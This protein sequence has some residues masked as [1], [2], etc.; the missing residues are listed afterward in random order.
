MNADM[1]E[2]DNHRV[3]HSVVR[4][5]SIQKAL[6]EANG[7]VSVDTI[8]AILEQKMPYGVFCPYYD[9]Y[10]GTLHSMVFDVSNTKVE[11]CLGM[12]Q[13]HKWQ[14]ISFDAPIKISSTSEK[15]LN[16]YADDPDTFWSVLPSGSMDV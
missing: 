11:I 4:Y 6:T 15:V 13:S 16:E 7:A 12:P 14:E 3:R 2:H 10:L 5:Q 9:D 8:K 1:L